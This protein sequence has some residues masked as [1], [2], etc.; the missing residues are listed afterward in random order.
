MLK[1]WN[2]QNRQQ[3]NRQCE[4]VNFE[5]DTWIL[6]DLRSK[7]EI[8][9][10]L[11]K[12]N[13]YLI[14]D[15]V[16]RASD[17]WKTLLRR[18]RPEFEVISK[19]YA[20]FLA[21]GFLR[22]LPN[23]DNTFFG[24]TE[25]AWLDQL[26]RWCS[27]AFSEDLQTELLSYLEQNQ[28]LKINIAKDFYFAK[29]LAMFFNRQKRVSAAWI[30]AILQDQLQLQ[31]TW[32]RPLW[33]DLRG[34]MSLIEA[35][36]LQRLSQVVDVNIFAPES[37]F[38]VE[39]NGVNRI[40]EYL[41]SKAHTFG[42]F[43]DSEATQPE[44]QSIFTFSGPLAEVK[45]AVGQVRHWLDAGVSPTQIGL[46]A[47]DIEEY[48][49]C[50][51][52]Y[53]ERE[54][55]PFQKNIVGRLSTFPQVRLWFSRL[56]ASLDH[57]DYFSLEKIHFRNAGAVRF[58]HEE[59]K[60]LLFEIYEESDLHRIEDVFRKVREF[61]SWPAQL[62]R[63]EFL[64]RALNFWRMDHEGVSFPEA[65]K[66]ALEK[67]L[68][69]SRYSDMASANDWLTYLE[70]ISGQTEI[71][72]K[73]GNEQGIL[74]GS[75]L[76][77]GSLQL[78]KIILLGVSDESLKSYTRL[79][80]NP[81]DAQ[82]LNQDLGLVIESNEK[83]L[84]EYELRWWLRNQRAEIQIFEP[85][86]DWQ[87]QLLNHTAFLMGREKRPQAF[88]HHLGTR[89][90]QIQNQVLPESLKVD[91][92]CD[93]EAIS[94]CIRRDLDL[95][96]SSEK[97]SWHLQELSPTS[98][99]SYLK[100]PFLF[101]ANKG[102]RL[103]DLDDVDVDLVHR[104]SGQFYHALVECLLEP[105]RKL[106][107]QDE[108]LEQL[109]EKLREHH[110]FV[111]N[112]DPTW[113]PRRNKFVKWSRHFLNFEIDWRR[114]FPATETLGLELPWRVPWKGGDFVMRGKI[115]RLDCNKEG[116][117]V[118][119]DYKSSTAGKTGPKSWLKN[120]DLQILFYL[121]ALKSGGIDD[122]QGEAIGAF[123]FDLKKL[124]RSKGLQVQC[125]SDLLPPLIRKNSG[126]SLLELA[127]L[128][129]AFQIKVDEVL[130]AMKAGHFSPVPQN[131]KD[132]PS[133]RWNQ[134][135]RAPHLN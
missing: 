43:S 47:P 103:Q 65:L 92:T 6:P 42:E 89:W 85:E 66:T 76:S 69:E 101:F 23:E 134:I 80:I 94:A 98:I 55:I 122:Y 37:E 91:L 61:S 28:D 39:Y 30:P 32:S 124:D 102:F 127:E 100:C 15:G 73:L 53:L 121:W 114:K 38:E 68:R 90:D 129:E 10:R 25:S 84:K 40:Y 29:I 104:Q 59:F 123:F 31:Q 27:V 72:E 135:C 78:Q 107:W 22:E 108:E 56:R 67:F 62:G 8:Q 126:I 133:C 54:G 11:F 75:L 14:E 18:A 12:Q 3:I 26:N 50:M 51:S 49:P 119:V 1:I 46:V 70:A 110:L 131:E 17:L 35:E 117:T 99:E 16:L 97:I 63:D 79:G 125:E 34:E 130:V 9:N 48:W 106:L 20:K 87:G 13:G 24:L 21:K 5:S 115:D 128:L 4:I 77:A 109:M 93:A 96:A 95:S 88:L 113:P 132:C 111:R 41:R 60:S 7:L 19:E 82:Q 105:S 71:C 36:L 83:K 52:S 57:K 44:S 64:A 74:V 2:V 116:Q 118:L 45:S 81:V 33:V 112:D 58:R 120:N 86:T